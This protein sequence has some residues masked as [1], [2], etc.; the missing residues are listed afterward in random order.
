MKKEICGVVRAELR[1]PS[2]CKYVYSIYNIFVLP[3]S[4]V[5]SISLSL[6]GDPTRVFLKPFAVRVTFRNRFVASRVCARTTACMYYSDTFVSWFTDNNEKKQ[7]N[8]TLLAG[9]RYI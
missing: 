8:T 3:R 5:N 1:V 9:P 7:A 2:D 6:L 4:L